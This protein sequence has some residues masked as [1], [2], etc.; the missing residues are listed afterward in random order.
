MIGEKR[1]RR[2]NE[3]EFEPKSREDG[4]DENTSRR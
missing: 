1:S 4:R 2:Y 3:D